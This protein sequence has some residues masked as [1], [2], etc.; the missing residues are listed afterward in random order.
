MF[1][2]EHF[3]AAVTTN[4]ALFDL[5]AGD[6]SILSGRV[7]IGL[8]HVE[9]SFLRFRWRILPALVDWNHP[10]RYKVNLFH[11]LPCGTRDPAVDEMPLGISTA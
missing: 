1:H 11:P 9:H 4:A 5:V 7:S 2:V 10:G 6:R 3:I 8:F